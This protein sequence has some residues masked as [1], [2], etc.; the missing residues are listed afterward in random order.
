MKIFGTLFPFV[1]SSDDSLR[2]GRYVANYEFL[3]ALLNYS[4]FD[5]F[6][7][8]CLSPGHFQS[9]LT[10]LSSDSSISQEAKSK[11]QL[12][13]FDILE[14]NLQNVEYHCFHLGGWGFFY[15]GT[16]ALRNRF[17]KVPF[18]V[19]GVIHSLNSTE[20]MTDAHKLVASPH[21]SYDS[22]VCTSDS[23]RDVLKKAVQLTNYNGK[24]F[25]GELI[26]IPLGYDSH[27]DTI[28]SKTEARDTLGIN[29]DDIVILYL[30]RISP[31]SKADLFPL[32]Q[33]FKTMRE[34]YGDSIKLII[35][36]GV[37]GSELRI[38][39]DMIHDLELDNA[40]RLM[41][42]FEMNQKSSIYS[43]SDIYVAPS[44]N[45]QE[46]FGISIIEA[47]AS[48]LPVVASDMDGY[49]ELVVHNETGFKIPTIWCSEHSLEQ[50]HELLDPGTL[51]M[52]LAQAMVVVPEKME[53]ALSA[54]IENPVL[55]NQ[56]GAKGKEIANHN[57]RWEVVIKQY[58]ELW[59]RLK[60]KAMSEHRSID[61][62]SS[63]EPN[64]LTLFS[65]YTTSL[66]ADHSLVKIRPLGK[67]LLETGVLPS[68]YSDMA[69]VLD[70]TI[71]AEVLQKVHDNPVSLSDLKSD[72]SK[73][74]EPT[75]L[76][77]AKYDLIG[78][79]H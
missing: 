48:G 6:H 32:L 2:L 31:S 51:Q 78:L 47:M 58:E 50:T 7:I 69:L 56:M 11:V 9:T 45:I 42:N 67:K 16:V 74:F 71:I 13:L 77:M 55:R 38:H 19:T 20:T 53:D 24:T 36:G 30:G 22:V 68:I 43:A 41:I 57:Y 15:A 23:G 25:S 29:R 14:E 17:A 52:L 39:K 40:V 66:F 28:P 34:R 10:K 49:R 12:F 18:P 1:E 8:Y 3:K 44:D 21:Q 65:H 62:K 5:S 70:Q 4:A 72:Y 64:Y 27:F 73:K 75:L 46:T 35:A 26:K 76:W 63:F 61:D 54:L 37:K 33:V 59:N 79:E 60:E